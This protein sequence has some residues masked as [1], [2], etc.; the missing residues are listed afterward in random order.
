VEL[1]VSKAHIYKF[2]AE[3]LNYPVKEFLSA[4]RS[5]EFAAEMSEAA[6]FQ[7]QKIR[8][9]IT[10]LKKVLRESKDF[11]NWILDLEKD[12][13]RMFLA[14]RPRLVHLFESVYKEGKLYQESTFEIARIYNQAG[15]APKEEFKLPPDHI[16]LEFELMAYLAFQETEAIHQGNQ[17]NQEYAH[18]LQEKVLNDHLRSFALNV[19]ERMAAHANTTFYRSV[20]EL[21]GV[22]LSHNGSGSS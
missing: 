5:R 9:A 13:T 10:Q 22:F 17:E 21:I 16:A 20:A 7:P 8:K 6:E 12:Y 19:A 2:L 18:F 3:A 15:L 1:S 11:E 14:S 4:I